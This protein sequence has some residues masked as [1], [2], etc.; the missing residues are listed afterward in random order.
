MVSIWLALGIPKD[1]RGRDVMDLMDLTVWVVCGN[2]PIPGNHKSI[3][4]FP[5]KPQI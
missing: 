3:G 5:G 2:Q 4:R 1:D